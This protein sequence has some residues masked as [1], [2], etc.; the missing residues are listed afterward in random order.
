[1][2]DY[3]RRNIEHFDQ[4]A[5]SYDASPFKVALAKKC[6]DAFLEAEGVKWDP[7]SSV[8]VD[9]ACGTGRLQFF[10]S[11]LMI[12]L[13]SQNIAPHAR[14]IVGLDTSQAMVDVYNTKATNNSLSAK[15]HALCVDILSVPDAALPQEVQEVDIVVCSMS[16]HHLENIDHA[17]KAVASLLKKGGYLLIVDLLQSL[18]MM[19]FSDNR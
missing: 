16:Y 12:G 18:L 3:T 5:T 4:R 8:V 7:S 1:M 17:T 9:F 2:S 13:I 6:S 10:C 15:M 14:T 11:I 19:G